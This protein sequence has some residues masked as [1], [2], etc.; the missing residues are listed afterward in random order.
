MGDG[1]L[2]MEGTKRPTL[3]HLFRLGSQTPISQDTHSKGS[4][5]NLNMGI[6]LIPTIY[7]IENNISCS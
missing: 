5:E 2:I 3:H 4:K 6:H 1:H 7:P